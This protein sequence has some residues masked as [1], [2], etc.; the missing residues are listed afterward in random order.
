MF[1]LITI[2]NRGALL[3]Y[4][5]GAIWG[6]L[7]PMPY[8]A[9]H[10]DVTQSNYYHEVTVHLE[11][12]YAQHDTTMIT[13]GLDLKIPQIEFSSGHDPRVCIADHIKA[14]LIEQKGNL[15][16]LLEQ[17]PRIG[18]SM[19]HLLPY[20]PLFDTEAVQGPVNLTCP[21]CE[22]SFS[23]GESA[24]WGGCNL[25]W[26]HAHCYELRTGHTPKPTAQRKDTI[27]NALYDLARCGILTPDEIRKLTSK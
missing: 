4:L 10:L 2:E 21:F 1:D 26:V 6:E 23:D 18:W 17:D 3:E 16:G 15:R 9:V 27:V 19:T 25:G 8:P 12:T 20:C 7:V 24:I 11:I 14:S 22:R 5:L 13:S